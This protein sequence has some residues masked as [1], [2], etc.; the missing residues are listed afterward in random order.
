MY[1]ENSFMPISFCRFHEEEEYNRRVR[2]RRARLI[3][4][5]EEAF[6]H[7]KRMQEEAGI[8][9]KPVVKLSKFL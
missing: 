5:A 3:V 6:T 8:Y 4:A 7:I 1:W 9:T 2:K